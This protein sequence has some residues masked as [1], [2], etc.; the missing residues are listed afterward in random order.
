[1]EL[2]A[3]LYNNFYTVKQ[4]YTGVTSRDVDCIYD[5]ARIIEK[6]MADPPSLFELSRKVGINENKLKSNF[7]LVFNNTVYGYLN[8]KRMIKAS[9]LL[10]NGN[11]TVQEVAHC[12]GFKHVGHFSKKFKQHYL[13]SPKHYRK[14]LVVTQQPTI[15]I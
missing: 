10:L 9:E 7:K 4:V 3:M 6:E 5:A 14:K 13:L 12:V 15:K 2:L 8:K 1:M 11:L